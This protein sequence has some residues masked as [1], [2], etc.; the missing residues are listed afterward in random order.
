M[1]H[2]TTSKNK[3]TNT[4]TKYKFI[5]LVFLNFISNIKRDKKI[6]YYFEMLD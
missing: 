4:N 3:D 1:K 6:K 2:K 5:E